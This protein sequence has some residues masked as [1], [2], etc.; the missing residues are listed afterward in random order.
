MSTASADFA[1]GM[2]RG[3]V[4]SNNQ[5]LDQAVARGRGLSRVLSSTADRFDSQ[6]L[7]DRV[8]SAEYLRGRRGRGIASLGQAAGLEAGVADTNI[9]A[10]DAR[11]GIRDNTLG[12]A[13]GLGAGFAIDRYRNRPPPDPVEVRGIDIGA[14]DPELTRGLA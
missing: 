2:P 9:A 5:A 11:R 14:Y 8:A 4:T 7:R 12:T 6:L 10:R 1:H 13:V 3:P